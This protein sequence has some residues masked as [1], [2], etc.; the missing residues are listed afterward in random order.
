M[1]SDYS[2]SLLNETIAIMK[3]SNIQNQYSIAKKVKL[4]APEFGATRMPQMPLREREDAIDETIE[5]II[6]LDI[7]TL[8]FISTVP[9]QVQNNSHNFPVNAASSG[10][11]MNECMRY[12]E[13]GVIF[14]VCKA[15]KLYELAPY[16][17]YFEVVPKIDAV[18]F[19]NTTFLDRTFD[20]ETTA[21]TTAAFEKAS[22][23]DF[24]E[25][26]YKTS[27][28][29]PERRL[30]TL[31]N[32]LNFEMDFRR[33]MYAFTIM[34]ARDT[35]VHTDLTA[36]ML[37]NESIGTEKSQ[38]GKRRKPLRLTTREG[39]VAS[40]RYMQV[41]VL[42]MLLEKNMENG[43]IPRDKVSSVILRKYN[44]LLAVLL[45]MLNDLVEYIQYKNENPE[46]YKALYSQLPL[47]TEPFKASQGSPVTHMIFMLQYA[48]NFATFIS[49]PL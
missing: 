27:V 26:F 34:F 19:N 47:I 37:K 11:L 20:G 9:D 35:Q 39:K 30:E 6:S 33:I 40:K 28:S 1:V 17:D 24:L 45:Q 10:H 21:T 36:F 25:D 44:E 13:C 15:V 38:R 12:R 43:D 16:N 22:L 48:L 41:I 7:A 42:F 32:L 46:L 18:T 23:L 2:E 3:A 31:E 5:N 8:K 29:S 4:F 14:A 49:K